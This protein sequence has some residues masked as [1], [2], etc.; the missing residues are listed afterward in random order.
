[1]SWNIGQR[2]IQGVTDVTH[3]VNTMSYQF[4]NTETM[5]GILDDYLKSNSGYPKHL[6]FY[7]DYA[8]R[9]MKSNSSYSDWQIIENYFRNKCKFEKRIKP[10][11]SIRDSIAATNAQFCNANNERKQ[12]VVKANCQDLIK[13]FEYCQWKD[14]GKELAETDVRRGHLCRAVDYYN[15]YEHST[16]GKPKATWRT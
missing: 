9:A 5:C 10:C 14:N 4:T 3:W 15:D 13:D 1:M 7:G 11:K 2:L 12:F 16:K 8:G 6:I